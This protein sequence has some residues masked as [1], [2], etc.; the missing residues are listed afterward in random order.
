LLR[1][2]KPRNVVVAAVANRWVRWLFHEAQRPLAAIENSVATK[3]NVE[4]K[5]NVDTA[6]R[7]LSSGS[8][9]GSRPFHLPLLLG[10]RRS[11]G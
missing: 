3:Y 4:S 8:T 5:I 2:G 10:P 6:P 1:R 9:K 11:E 7:D